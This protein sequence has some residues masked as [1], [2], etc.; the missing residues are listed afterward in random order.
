MDRLLRPAKLEVLPEKPEATRIYDHW[1][2]SFDAILEAARTAAENADNI[3]KLS[4][5]TNLLTHERFAFIAD[6]TNNEEAR[7]VLNN[8]YHRRKTIVF[9]RH[10]LMTRTQKPSESINEYVHILRQLARDCTFQ[11]VTAEICKDE[12]TRDAFISSINSRVSA[13]DCLKIT[14]S[15]FKLL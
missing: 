7:E 10:L 6:S 13:S 3:N 5:L 1:L 12:L 2:K 11:N 8:A 4:L 14:I 15:I 9:A